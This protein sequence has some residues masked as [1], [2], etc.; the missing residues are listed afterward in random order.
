M[1]SVFVSMKFSISKEEENVSTKENL[2]AEDKER[3]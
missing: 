3:E 1:V 2:Y